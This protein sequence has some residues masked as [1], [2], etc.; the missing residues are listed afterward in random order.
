MKV[1]LPRRPV[2]SPKWVKASRCLVSEEK[3]KEWTSLL[4]P[5]GARSSTY[6]RMKWSGS[7]AAIPRENARDRLIFDMIYRYGLRRREAAFLRLEQISER[8]W[9]NR[10]KGGVPGE[11]PIHPCTRRLLWAYLSER[12]RD[13]ERPY[14]FVTR[15]SGARRMSPST[16][17]GRFRIYADAA[18]IPREWQHPHVLSQ[19]GEVC[20]VVALGRH[21]CE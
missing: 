17:Y 21:C 4:S 11:Y 5:P 3:L 14:L 6:P 16:I 18:G 12:G 2:S 1:Q 8:I 7:F 10:L 9:I 20:R 15:Q 19:G 13:D